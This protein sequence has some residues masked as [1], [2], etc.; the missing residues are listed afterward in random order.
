M[1]MEMFRLSNPGMIVAK[2]MS[3]YNG[4]S[5]AQSVT[6]VIS[7]DNLGPGTAP[8][9]KVN[10]LHPEADLHGIISKVSD[11][12]VGAELASVGLL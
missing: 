4:S 5:T 8:S 3:P 12:K 1:T 6:H 10:I 2:S 9:F 7:I 11:P